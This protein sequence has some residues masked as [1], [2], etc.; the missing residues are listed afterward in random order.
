MIQEGGVE[1]QKGSDNIPSDDRLLVK[2][3]ENQADHEQVRYGVP[4]FIVKSNTLSVLHKPSS[5]NFCLM[6][7][8]LATSQSM[9][10]SSYATLSS[11]V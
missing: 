1:A 3:L 11:N 8:N 7:H 9:H 2:W 6:L 10:A 4:I 5:K